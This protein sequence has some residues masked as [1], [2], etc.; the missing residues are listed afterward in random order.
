MFNRTFVR[1]CVVF[2]AVFLVL[3]YGTTAFI[4]I[5]G[6]GGRYYNAW[7]AHNLNYVA[8]LR[9]GIL[10]GAC[11]IMRLLG[12]DAH[13]IAPFSI[14]ILHSATVQMVYSC[15]GYGVISFW[16]AFI[17]ANTASIKTKLVWGLC[18]LAAIV[19]SNMLR[20]CVLL[21]AIDKK[22]PTFFKIDHHTFYNICSYVIVIVLIWAFN[23]KISKQYS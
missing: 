8:W 19:F 3:Y 13:V 7:L 1:Y 11:G 17:V 16:L 21:I 22:W 2:M 6:E 10:Y 4:G 12:F 5:T 14:H 15:L 9:G 18:G 20:V 23:R